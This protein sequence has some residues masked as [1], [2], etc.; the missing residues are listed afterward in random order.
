MT[1][2]CEGNG[3]ARL[4]TRH[5]CTTIPIML[6]AQHRSKNVTCEMHKR[7]AAQL[8]FSYLRTPELEMHIS[9]ELHKIV[10]QER[11]G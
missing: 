3:I 8:N 7:V 4:Q 2:A 9:P 10:L 6:Q 1:L 11:V 5:L